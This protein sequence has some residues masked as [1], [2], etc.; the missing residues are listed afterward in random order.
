MIRGFYRNLEEYKEKKRDK[1]KKIYTPI[2]GLEIH[3][4]LGTKSKMFCGCRND[5]FHAGK[6]NIYTCP[7][8]L[9]LPGA[10]PVPNKRAIEMTVTAG[11]ALGCRINKKSRFD[12]KHYFYPD[13]PKGYQISQYEK[14]FCVGGKLVIARSEATWQSRLKTDRH[15]PHE[16]GAR[17]DRV[18]RIRR[19]HLEED[20][21]K[22]L[23]RTID[24][25][26]VSL[27]DFNRSG[28][29]LLEIVTEPDIRSAGEAKLVARKIHQIVRFLG[30]SDADMEKGS[31]RLE[32]NVSL[33]SVGDSGTIFSGDARRADP[34]YHFLDTLGSES[35]LTSSSPPGQS[36]SKVLSGSSSIV[37]K[38]TSSGQLQLPSY[39]VELK[40]INSFRFLERAIDQEIARQKEILSSNKAVVQQT[41][42]WDT[43]KQE[44]KPQRVK[45]EAADY[46]YFPEPDIPP[47]SLS[48]RW[49]SDIR[50]QISD[51]PDEV[52]E[53]LIKAGVSGQAAEVISGNKA[54]AEI[55]M[56]GIRRIRG[57]RGNKGGIREIGEM[58]E[59]GNWV[60]H[61]RQEAEAFSA[62]DLVEMFRKEKAEVVGD[63]ARLGKWVEEAVAENRKAVEDYRKG[64]EA[65][66]QFLIGQVQKKAKGKAEVL[67]VKRILLEKLR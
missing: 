55:A 62:E 56:R 38:M 37:S 2:I 57:E 29:P 10:L 46:R 63:E 60:L 3:V 14:P 30:I 67:I 8:C 51:L 24:G 13:L 44:L 23:H 36:K 4:E 32:A 18:V 26:E 6:P 39:K 33:L 11:L 34:R 19:V 48:D 50:N 40:N 27:I 28:V 15:A 49:I 25:E 31:M 58:R 52:F 17:D 9:G 42:G 59:F 5:P 21:G 16:D 35:S 12:R 54:L 43:E 64:K 66:L 61:H 65:A 7:V 45:E 20:T 1:M 47:I 41:F 22:L 53:K